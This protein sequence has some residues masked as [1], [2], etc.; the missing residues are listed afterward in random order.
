LS[1]SAWRVVGVRFDAARALGGARQASRDRA[2]LKRRARRHEPTRKALYAECAASRV[3][4]MWIAVLAA[5]FDVAVVVRAGQRPQRFASPALLDSSLATPQCTRA[6]ASAVTRLGRDSRTLGGS[7]GCFTMLMTIR[8]STTATNAELSFGGDNDD[9][10]DDDNDNDN[11]DNNG[12]D[13]SV[14][15]RPRKRRGRARESAIA[16]LVRAPL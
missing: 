1:A 11:D 12:N 16:E 10:N 6:Q 3:V 2:N 8:G 7:A 9:D 4:F 5:C 13:D 15:E 14:E